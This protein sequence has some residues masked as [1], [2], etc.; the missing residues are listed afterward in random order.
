MQQSFKL[1]RLPAG[2]S[3]EGV[4]PQRFLAAPLAGLRATRAQQY[5]A[6]RAAPAPFGASRRPYI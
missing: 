2:L 5:R 1:D 4:A 3:S 6:S